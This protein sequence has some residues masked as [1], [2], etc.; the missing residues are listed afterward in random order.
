M[1]KIVVGGGGGG[2]GGDARANTLSRSSVSEGRSIHF[3]C[4]CARVMGALSERPEGCGISFLFA[5][6]AET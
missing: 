2:G 4:R 3:S 6:K 5:L 1:S